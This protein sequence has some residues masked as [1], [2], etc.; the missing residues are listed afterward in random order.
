M[1]I[2]SGFSKMS[3]EQKINWLA[4]ELN[5]EASELV[6]KMKIFYWAYNGLNHGIKLP[7]PGKNICNFNMF[8]IT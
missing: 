7:L 4:S 8:K 2:V 6:K 3:K 5:G 1:K